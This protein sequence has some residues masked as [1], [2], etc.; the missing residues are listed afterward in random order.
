[1]VLDE[2]T[3]FLVLTNNSIFPD[4]VPRL[5]SGLEV[6]RSASELAL[7][8]SALRM[9]PVDRQADGT[10]RSRS[11]MTDDTAPDYVV[12]GDPNYSFEAIT[13][14]VRL[15]RDGAPVH[16]DEPRATGPSA[17]RPARDGAIAA[18]DREGHRQPTSSKP[19]DP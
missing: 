2:G 14:A 8:D 3:E 13:K 18:D 19:S 1:M 9:I 11:S 12:V 16:R 15:I 10:A 6:P 4:H 7:A 5:L 17:R